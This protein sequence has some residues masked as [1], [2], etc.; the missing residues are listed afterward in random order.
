LRTDFRLSPVT[1]T[2]IEFYLHG[3]DECATLATFWQ[4]IENSGLDIFNHSKETGKEQYEVALAPRPDPVKTAADTEALKSLISEAAMRHGMRADFSAKPFADRPGCG[5][6]IHVHLADAQGKNVFYKDDQNI[7][8]ALQYSIGGLLATMKENMP[9]FA[10]TPA[11]YA[12]FVP[13][14]DVPLTVSWGANNRTVAVRLPQS[15]HA[16]KHI[17]HRVAGADADPAKVMAAILAG[18]N[19]GLKNRID[20]GPQIFGDAALPMYNLPKILESSEHVA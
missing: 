2:E 19:I 15:A 8:A 17:E 4:E 9:L 3:S 1:A 16:N 10:P 7:S 18:M 20:P 6:H 5:L 12:R 14:G 13:G 11:S